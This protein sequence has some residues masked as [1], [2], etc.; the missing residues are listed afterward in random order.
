M[1]KNSMKESKQREEEIRIVRLEKRLLKADARHE[2][3]KNN[4]MK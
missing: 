3:L 1:K 2:W 4:N